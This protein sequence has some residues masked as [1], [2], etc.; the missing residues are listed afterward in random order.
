MI[1]P[2]M[3]SPWTAAVTM[4]TKPPMLWPTGMGRS[5]PRVP[6]TP[7]TSRAHCFTS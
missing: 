5:M 4:V 2:A 7:S 6:A 3:S 1:V